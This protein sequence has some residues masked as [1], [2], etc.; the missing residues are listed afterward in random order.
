MY[1]YSIDTGYVLVKKGNSHD[2]HS[3]SQKSLYKK[4]PVK[5]ARIKKASIKK[6][7]SKKLVSKKPLPWEDCP[8]AAYDFV[9]LALFLLRKLNQL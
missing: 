9:E 1:E 5:K 8:M 7:R 3:P 6:L 4:A 2:K